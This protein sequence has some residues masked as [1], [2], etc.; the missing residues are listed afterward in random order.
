MGALYNNLTLNERR[1]LFRLREAKLG[2][3]RIAERIGRHRSTIY[4]ELQRNWHRDVETPEISGYYPTVAHEAAACRRYRHGKLQRDDR[5]AAEVVERLRQAWSPEQIAGRMRLERDGAATV[6]HETIYRYIYG[7][8]GYPSGECR[9]RWSGCGD[10]LLFRAPVPGQQL[11]Q[12]GGG[13]VS[14][15]AEDISEPGA[16]INVIQARRD[17][18]GID[19]G[20]ALTTTI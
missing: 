14:D 15:A 9:W 3:P 4:R 12:P 17:D 2:V 19:S 1:L 16:R 5:V 7:P 6:C 8:A 18:E 13:V 20:S 11:V 10:S